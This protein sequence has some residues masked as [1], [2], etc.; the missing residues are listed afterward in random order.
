[1]VGMWG[2]LMNDEPTMHDLMLTYCRGPRPYVYRDFNAP[3]AFGE[4]KGDMHIDEFRPIA[5]S[6]E[7]HKYY[8]AR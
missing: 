4:R 1:M 6:T 8:S 2:M 7:T 5:T 3:R